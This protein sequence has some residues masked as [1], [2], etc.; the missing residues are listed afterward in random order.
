MTLIDTTLQ[1]FD[2]CFSVKLNLIFDKVYF[3]YVS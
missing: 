3:L 2:V 1:L